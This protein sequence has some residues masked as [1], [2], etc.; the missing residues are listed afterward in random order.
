MVLPEDDANRQLANGFHSGIDRS[1]ERQMQILPPVGGWR[2]VLDAFERDHIRAL[3]QYPSRVL[4]LLIDFDQEEER[5]AYVKAQIPSSLT[6]RVFVLGVWSEPEK[7]KSAG[8]GSFEDIGERLAKECR[9]SVAPTWD[10][11]L[12]RHNSPELKRLREVVAPIFF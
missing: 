10:H 8:L 5:L 2:R 12:L 6:E 7:L 1:V 4:V 3:V 11:E 9:Q